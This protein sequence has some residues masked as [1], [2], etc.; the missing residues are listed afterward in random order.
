LGGMRKEPEPGSQVSSPERDPQ[1]AFDVQAM[2]HLC[3][4][5]DASAALVRWLAQ[6][7]GCWAGLL[8]RSGAVLVGALPALGPPAVSLVAV[9]LEDMLD[10]GLRTFVADGEAHTAVLL[11]VDVP[12]GA[13]GPVLA[14]VGAASVP[15]SLAADAAVLLGTCW[16]VGET[17]RIRE[18]VDDADARCREAV[19]HLLM[20]RHISTAVQ[21]ASALHPPLPDPLRVH[22]IECRGDERGEMVRRSSELAGESAFIV[23]CPVYRRHVI[24]LAPAQNGGSVPGNRPLEVALAED[25]SGCVAGAGDVVALRDTAVGYEQAIHALSVARGRAERSARFDAKLDLPTI[26]GPEGLRWASALLNPLI[27]YIPA[28]STD[29]NAQEL[30]AT[31]QSWLQF[32]MAATRH[33]KIHRNTLSARLQRI[34]ELLGLD[35]A[36]ADQ[37]ALLDLALRIRATPRGTETAGPADPDTAV[38]LNELM[39]APAVQQWARTALRPVR[40]AA[41]TTPL[42]STL[43]AWVGSNSR[44]S[45]TAEEL[46]ISVS[47]A[48]KRVGRLEQVLHRS[49]LHG[50]SA[51]HDLWLAMH[52]ADLSPSA[53]HAPDD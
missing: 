27:T 41:D 52:A 17:H 25:V 5:P 6:R 33:L 18:Q 48:R 44:L 3:R 35:L 26:V 24:V 42:E 11:T 50:P 10:R 46:G 19:L 23:R 30:T 21:I 4:R 53:E 40:E 13:L 9:A 49:L 29:P 15:R 22:I 14:F 45:A 36:R 37:Q 12:A 38:E 28:R 1:R 7:T 32:S 16:W 47:G 8:D 43:R 39:R 51:R 31:A 2:H 20:S 34:E